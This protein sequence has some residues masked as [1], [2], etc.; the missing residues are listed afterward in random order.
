MAMG[1][2]GAPSASVDSSLSSEG[3]KELPTL[4]KRDLYLF[5]LKREPVLMNPIDLIYTAS[6]SLIASRYSSNSNCM[7]KSVWL[8]CSNKTSLFG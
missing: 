5:F 6:R 1:V 3:L 8:K 7:L 4:H 2:E